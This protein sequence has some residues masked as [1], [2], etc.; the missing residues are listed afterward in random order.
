[1]ADSPLFK[2]AFVRG[3]NSELIRTGAL[4]YPSKEAADHA[5]DYIADNSGMPDPFLQGDALTQKVASDLCEHLVGASQ[6]LCKEAGDQYSPS[7]TKTAQATDPSTTAT[8]EAWALMEKSAAETGSLMEGGDNPNDQPAAASSNAEAALEAQRRPENYANM[9]EEGVGNYERKGQGNVGTEEKHPEKPKATDEGSNSV[10]ENTA[11][12]GSLASII[13][14]VAAGTGSLMDPGQEQ[15][16]QPAAASGNA[17]AALEAQRRPEN[18]ANK[19]EDGVGR[20]DMVPGTNS[21]VGSEQAHPL[22]PK[23]TDSGKTNVPIEHIQGSDGGSKKASAFDQLFTETAQSVVPY[24]PEQMQ[25]QH[26]VAHVR[27]MMGLEDTQRA[28]YLHDLYGQLGSEKNAAELVRDHFLKTAAEAASR[29][30]APEAETEKLG[31][32]LPPALKAH[33]KGEGKE[34]KDEESDDSDS[35]CSDC[36]KKNCE[37]DKDEGLPMPKPK[38]EGKEFPMGLEHKKEASANG[39]SRNSLSSLRAALQNINA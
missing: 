17:E 30:K 23:A 11:K 5:A 27:A 21:Q 20:S 6:H 25:E 33:M 28:A 8:Q 18:Y 4:V 3:L 37:C 19:G 2:R 22:A 31:K 36:G 12:H 14:K 24:L 7:V 35:K 16:D 9:G 38:M 10:T 34:D 15:N 26:K 39:A 13:Q 1:M 29:P 32:E